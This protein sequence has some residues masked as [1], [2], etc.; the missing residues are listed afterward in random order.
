MEPLL[1]Q[2]IKGLLFF[3]FLLTLRWLFRTKGQKFTKDLQHKL[4]PKSQELLRY[5][6]RP[7][8]LRINDVRRKT[9]SG[10]YQGKEIQAKGLLP[11]HK[12][13]R[14][15]FVTSIFDNTN[16]DFQPVHSLSENFREESSPAYQ[17]V[18]FQP[19]KKLSEWSYI[20]NFS[21]SLLVPPFSGSRGLVVVV[22]MMDISNPP[23]EREL[24]Y[25]DEWNLKVLWVQA[26]ALKHTFSVPGYMENTAAKTT[27]HSDPG[28][29]E[30]YKTPN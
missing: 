22:R 19:G 23:P 1:L 3:G 8:H 27:T 10:V 2:I 7:F 28:M 20:S 11:V 26:V 16:G 5:D 15:A 12:E 18:F 17:D 9:N 25:S 21:P 24:E 6:K 4:F 30:F 14:I 29:L 13:T